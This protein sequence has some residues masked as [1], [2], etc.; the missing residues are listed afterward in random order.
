M[1]EVR[2]VLQDRR[3]DRSEV[4][5][6]AR[7]AE[8]LEQAPGGIDHQLQ[9]GIAIEVFEMDNLTPIRELVQAYLR[10][11][12]E[13]P[14]IYLPMIPGISGIENDRDLPLLGVIGALERPF[15]LISDSHRSG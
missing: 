7:Q 11:P 4:G 3:I 8:T 14:D 10:I 1:S 15:P 6:L 13:M 5:L 9:A 12:M 2:H